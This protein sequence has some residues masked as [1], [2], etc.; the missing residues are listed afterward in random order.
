MKGKVIERFRD[1]FNWDTLYEV[2]TIVDFDEKRMEDLIAR[3]LC[4]KLEGQEE[5]PAPKV[6]NKERKKAPKKNVL[7]DG[8][9][10]K[11]QEE[12]PKDEVTKPEEK[13][14]EE[15]NDGELDEKTKSEQ[16]AAKKI[17]EATKKAEKK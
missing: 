16:E 15:N 1:K 13:T 8:E 14:A 9:E 5:T 2:G 6:N 17:A 11:K 10:T 7:D 12:N 3:K 4:E